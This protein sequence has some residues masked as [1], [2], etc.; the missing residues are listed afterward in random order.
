MQQKQT[1][2]KLVCDIDQVFPVPE[3]S[4]YRIAKLDGSHPDKLA[5]LDTKI[6]RD[7][8]S[9]LFHVQVTSIL[10]DEELQAKYGP[11][12]QLYFECLIALTNLE[13]SRYADNKRS[14]VYSTSALGESA[15]FDRV[16]NSAAAAVGVTLKLI[17]TLAVSH[18]ILIATLRGYL[19]NH[20]F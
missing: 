12:E 2:I 14:I 17:Q 10:D 19:L 13:L 5:K 11:E 4:I 15:K 18:V 9:G 7:M 8:G 1:G 20:H 3:V 6:E 16:E